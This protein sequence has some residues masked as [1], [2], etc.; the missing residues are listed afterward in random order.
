[1]QVAM[2]MERSGFP[3]VFNLQG[4]VDAWARMVDPAMS[5]Y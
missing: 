2:Y 3:R 4:G 1:M 5:R